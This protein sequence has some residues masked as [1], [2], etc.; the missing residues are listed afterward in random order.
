MSTGDQAITADRGERKYL[1]APDRAPV[2]ARALGERLELHHY[3]GED[4]NRLPGAQHFVTTIYFD[5]AARDIYQAARAADHSIKL[6]A[7]EYYDL[8]PALSELAT[9]PRQLVRYSPVLWL[10]IKE[11]EGERTRKRR[12][13]LPKADVSAFLAERH[14][15]PEMVSLQHAKPAAAQAALAEI[16]ALLA[17]LGPVA[18]DCLVNYRRLAW[19]DP[20]SSLRVTIDV[21]LS[22]YGPPADLWTRRFAMVRE[23][24]GAA[25]ASERSCVVEV[26]WRG[27]RPD[28]LDRL[29]ADVGARDGYYSKFEAA[30]RAVHADGD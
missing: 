5:T 20:D 9:D 4:A 6:R 16:G 29:L 30:S 13:A 25:R 7:K 3:A 26:K 14:V 22:F 17:R 2:L 18:A 23:S 28:W 10:E 11:K 12:L 8:H 15:T 19:Q 1:V 27:A 21:Q 24:L